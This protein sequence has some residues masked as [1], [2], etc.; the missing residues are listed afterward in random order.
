[1][2]DPQVSDGQ[3][4]KREVY[5]D[6]GYTKGT[7][8]FTQQ[9]QG[10]QG[11]GMVAWLSVLGL[12][13]AMFAVAVTPAAA[14]T[15]G[16]VA[17]VVREIAPDTDTAENLVEAFGG[18]VGSQLSIIGGFSATVPAA[19]VDT[20]NAD[21]SVYAATIDETLA[22]REV[23]SWGGA[24]TAT[25]LDDVT[26]TIGADDYWSKR[27][28]GK[29]IDIAVI[30][31][32]VSPVDGLDGRNRLVNGPD[33][34]FES[35]NPDFRYLDANGHGTHMA[36]IVGAY[37][38]EDDF[39]LKGVAFKSRI[40]NVKVGAYDGSV[41]VSQ[42]IAAIDWV[43]QHKNDDDLNIRVL[44][45]SYGTD[46]LQDPSIDPLSFAVEQ[47]WKDGIAVVVAGGNDGP[48]VPLN[49]PATNPYVIA[50]G[51]TDIQG[52]TD[53]SNDSVAAFSSCGVGRTVDVVAPGASIMSLHV[54]NSTADLD[55]PEAYERMVL[56]GMAFDSFKGSGSSQAAA[57]VSGAA[58]LIIDQRPDITP[59]QLKQLLI[60]SG[61]PVDG[62]ADCQGAGQI[63]LGAAQYMDTP[64]VVQ[65][66]LPAT[67]TGSLEAARGS[68]HVG[69][70]GVDLIGEQDIHGTS[71]SGTSWSM[72]SANGT[73][74]SGGDWNGTSWSGTSWSGTS[75][76]GTSWSGTSW[77][78]TSWSGT[79]WSNQYWN[80][81]SWSGTS[82]S[83]TSWS[84]TSWSGTSWSGVRWD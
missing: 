63:D 22:P 38:R 53:T 65:D 24:G 55:H 31:T 20:L 76:S 15:D 67:G 71:W 42:V 17:V 13:T 27:H 3:A 32:G 45:L 8:V 44:N 77:S 9:S 14:S 25:T 19:M 58:A 59:D 81:T 2:N 39:T 66:H 52:D 18:A 50:V 61:R 51:A 10:R 40:V 49:N 60:D 36:G 75:W 48:G 43:V 11:S 78:G 57:V 70:D 62:S 23:E 47:A 68:H 29:G 34:S 7:L 21:A 69:M 84:G 30:D 79:S 54:P 83:G 56:D 72:A 5:G 35:Q 41:D 33:L 16:D 46:S 4:P 12:I 80:G 82:W 74:W 6:A 37:D 26:K 28:K 73:S 64:S 1:M